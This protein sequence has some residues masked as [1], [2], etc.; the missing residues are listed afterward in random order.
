M[1][2]LVLEGPGGEAALDLGALDPVAVEVADAD[3]DVAGQLA[4]QVRHRE[5]A[6]VDRRQ[7][8]VE[9]LESPG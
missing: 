6:L 1:V 5:A 2:D 9:R 8:V 3:V 7:L 4:A